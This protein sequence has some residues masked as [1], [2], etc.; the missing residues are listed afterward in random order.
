MVHSLYYHI[1]F[2]SFSCHYCDFV[3]TS[4]FS[5]STNQ[6]YFDNLEKQTLLWFERLSIDRKSIP[7][8]FLGGGT[9]G[10]FT[11]EY[12]RLFRAINEY[13]APDAEIGLEVNPNNINDESLRA[14]SGLG[15]NRISIGVQTFDSLGLNILTRDH[16]AGTVVSAIQKAQRYFDNVSLDLIYGW[17]E[18][19]LDH[20]ERDLEKAVDLQVKHLSCYN[21][22][23][24]E[25]TPFAK[26][27][28]RKLIQPLHEDLE[29]A[30]Y[31]I[32]CKKLAAAGYRHYEV[33]NWAKEGFGSRHNQRYWE[34]R[35][36]IAVGSGAH[37]FVD[38]GKYGHRYSYS[39]RIPKYYTSL[40]VIDVVTDKRGQQQWLEE[41]LLTGLRTE[42]GIVLEGKLGDI[43]TSKLP[44][45]IFIM[46]EGRLR[47]SEKEWFRTNT[48]IEYLLSLVSC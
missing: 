29:E 38:E 9:P 2:C 42:K 39:T 44:K 17:P 37:G 24:E 5:K 46:H 40:S 11:L 6:I 25:G 18:Q 28:K 34:M 47:L 31:T 32:A 22:T 35:H 15:F 27:L 43:D 36:Y 20:W 45:D 16:T 21:L 7:A 8:V 3:K 10:L 13:L 14:W 26:K 19:T 41:V 30:M 48:H 33:S 1:P 4:D 23:F 12:S